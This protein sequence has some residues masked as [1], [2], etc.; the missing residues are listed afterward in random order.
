MDKFPAVVEL[1]GHQ[2]IAGFVSEIQVA[3]SPFLNVE[4]PSC[5]DREGFTRYYSPSAIYCINPTTEQVMLDAVKDFVLPP[6]NRNVYDPV[7][8]S[9]LNANIYDLYVDDDPVYSSYDEYY[10]D[11]DPTYDNEFDY[12]GGNKGIAY[13][14]ESSDE[15]QKPDEEIP[16]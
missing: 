3:G 9:S 12:D 13:L 8:S 5:D 16:F 11:D 6:I 2:R 10:G 14:D 15:E 1:L 7:R 4:V